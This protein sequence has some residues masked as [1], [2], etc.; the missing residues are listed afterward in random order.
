MNISDPFVQ[1][2][3]TVELHEDGSIEQIEELKLRSTYH[4][5][6]SSSRAVKIHFTAIEKSLTASLIS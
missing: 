1:K 4:P 2:D 3:N 6:A 5:L